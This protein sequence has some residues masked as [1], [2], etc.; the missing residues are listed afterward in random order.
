MAD[1]EERDMSMFDDPDF[2]EIFRFLDVRFTLTETIANPL[3]PTRPTISFSGDIRGI[4]MMKGT[5]SMTA[6]REVR[7]KFVSPSYLS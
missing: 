6:E 7:W 1:E 2:E 3:F 5:G 4:Y